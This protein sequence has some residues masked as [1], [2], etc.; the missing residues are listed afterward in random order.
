M[1]NMELPVDKR[2]FRCNH[3]NGK[4]LIPRN[5]PQTTGPCPH[6][7][8][9]ITSPPPDAGAVPPL[10][11]IPVSVQIPAPAAVQVPVSVSVPVAPAVSSSP[12]PPA[13]LPPPSPQEISQPA[14]APV[15][16]PVQA[17]VAPPPANLGVRP[18]VIP[19]PRE[20]PAQAAPAPLSEPPNHSG[21]TPEGAQVQQ[22]I[23][24]P[25][26]ADPSH[27]N[28]RKHK[29]TSPDGPPRKK[30]GLIPAMLIGLLL[31][32][33]AGAA[34]FFTA[35]EMREKAANVVNPKPPAIAPDPSAKE[36]GYIRIGWQKDAYQ[37]LGN[38]MAATTSAD[39]LPFILNGDRLGTR[40]E[41]FY[42]GGVINDSDTPAEA[43]SIYELSEEDRKRGL[44]MMIY[45]QPPQ[46][47]MKEFF[48]PLAPLE[49]QYGIDEADLLLSTLA[50]VGNFAMEPLRVHAFFKRTP[51]GLKLDWEIFAQ[52]K[53]RTFQNFVELPETGQIGT[54]RVFIVEDVPDKSRI[55]A[56]TRTYRMADPA[57]TG[58]TARVNVKV[59]SETGRALSIINWRG[60]KE[61]RPITRTATVELKWTGDASSPELEIS[62]FICWEFLGLGGQETPSTAST[63]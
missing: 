34:F 60:A 10:Q 28:K 7:N 35:A 49:V 42:G 3:C 4:I 45:D 13:P 38:Y 23:E 62:R 63:H 32:A 50:R 5:L 25:H 57:N 27:A 29:G 19:P 36:A 47:E 30:S 41:D 61:S 17:S 52:T 58:D 33:G 31:V 18:A 24:I 2:E 37:L 53:Y 51:E 11:S 15:P 48:R 21:G 56:G 20:K 44:F 22:A 1:A 39:K 43:F 12:P 6:C 8:A 46:F 59:D 16:L 55:E 26:A 40:L 54:F 9:V 14:A